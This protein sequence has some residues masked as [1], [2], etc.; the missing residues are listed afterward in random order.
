MSNNSWNSPAQNWRTEDK[1]TSYPVVPI[2][3]ES[4]WLQKVD[5]TASDFP[6]IEPLLEEGLTDWLQQNRVLPQVGKARWFLLNHERRMIVAAA[7]LEEPLRAVVQ[8]TAAQ[9]LLNHAPFSERIKYESK[10]TLADSVVTV[11]PLYTRNHQECFALLGCISPPSHPLTTGEMQMLSMFYTSLFYKRFEYTYVADMLYSAT[12]VEREAQRRSVLFQVIQRMYD[13][14]DIQELISEL[15]DIVDHMYPQVRFELLVAQDSENSNPRVRLLQ[16]QSPQED[17]CVRAFTTGEVAIEVHAQ[18]EGTSDQMETAIPLMGKQGVYGVFH[19]LSEVPLEEEDLELMVV[20]AEAAGRTFENAKLYEQSKMMNEDLRLINDISRRLNQNLQLKQ[21]FKFAAEELLRIFKADYVLVLY[22]NPDTDCFEVMDGNVQSLEGGVVDKNEGLSG[23]IYRNREPIILSD[24]CNEHNTE[25]I[26]MRESG[27]CSLIASP[28]MGGGEV[29][30]AIYLGHKDRH[31]FS[32][33]NFKL[34]Q[35]ITTHIGLAVSNA[36]LHAELSRMA[37]KDALTGLYQ[38]RYLDES[39]KNY[40]NATYSGSLLMVDID[41][42]KAV[43]DTFGHQTGD[44]VLKQVSRVVQQQIRD[45]D[46]AARWGG[47]ELAVYFPQV[48]KGRAQFIAERIR[49]AVSEETDP[50]V[51]VSCGIADWNWKDKE[52][53][54]ES[55]FY[56]AD[57]ALYQAKNSGRDQ[58]CVDSSLRA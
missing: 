11:A 22:L 14:F 15:F 56:R 29:N 45:G 1:L 25:S 44:E 54:V 37:S 13:K 30:G 33:D 18:A 34:L 55:L 50:H 47:E 24:Y 23:V 51:T 27:A 31:Y 2:A 8:H 53:S 46:I 21:I 58:V 7:D 36:A 39:I 35:V 17:M 16:L 38:R 10:H 52:V 5:I 41:K 49:I 9:A 48:D 26:F 3:D 40:Q 6:H 28:M 42:F 43:N 32:Y 19:L 4:F 57:R 12:V 20:I